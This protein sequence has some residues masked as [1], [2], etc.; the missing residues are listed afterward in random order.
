MWMLNIK[1]NKILISI[2]HWIV[3]YLSDLYYMKMVVEMIRIIWIWG[4]K[5]EMIYESLFKLY[6]KYSHLCYN[7]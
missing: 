2:Y 6:I 5:S 7:R 3:F 1:W 4:H